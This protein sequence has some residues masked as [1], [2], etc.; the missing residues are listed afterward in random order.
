[1][2]DPERLTAA[3]RALYA[4]N[5]RVL[6]GFRL[7]ETDRTHIAALLRL[8]APRSHGV[9]VD[10]GCGFGE[11][12]RIM[13]ELRPDLSFWLVNN[14]TYQLS[15]APDDMPQFCFD[16]HEMK[17][18]DAMFDGAMMLYS[19]CHAD[20]FVQVLR[21]A[22]RVT[23]P[24]GQLFVFDYARF[25]GDDRLA[26]EHLAARFPPYDWL[27]GLAAAGGWRMDHAVLPTGDDTVFRSLFE[28]QNLYE[29][30]FDGARPV[31]WWA[32]KP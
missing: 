4:R 24:G 5:L 11:P 20:D 25:A 17:F 10:I 3:S 22:A 18:E 7:A 26:V 21:E 29:S 30:I 8:M 15:M 32:T 31:I 12:A 19:L 2:I 14:N 6:Q 28:D 9:W 13:R 27:R 16:M 1:M 23:K